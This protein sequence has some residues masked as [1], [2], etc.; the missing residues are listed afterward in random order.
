MKILLE[1][2]CKVAHKWHPVAKFECSVDASHVACWLSQIDG[3]TYRATD[4]RWPDE[5]D[6]I[7]LYINGKVS[8]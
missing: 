7:T 2:K 5:G 4:N 8:A 3:V 6:E 1:R